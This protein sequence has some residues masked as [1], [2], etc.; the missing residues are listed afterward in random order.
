MAGRCLN[1]TA[2]WHVYETLS[3]PPSF[4]IGTGQIWYSGWEVPRGAS[5]GFYVREA[6]QSETSTEEILY[7]KSR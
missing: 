1:S 6:F 5:F 2:V 3:H 7:N 4:L